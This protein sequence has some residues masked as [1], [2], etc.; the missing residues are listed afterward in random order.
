LPDQASLQWLLRQREQQQDILDEIMIF[1]SQYSLDRDGD[2]SVELLHR[3]IG[4]ESHFQ[5]AAECST[6]ELKFPQGSGIQVN[7]SMS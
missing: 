7:V 6:L 2:L 5:L 4:I 3:F 1:I